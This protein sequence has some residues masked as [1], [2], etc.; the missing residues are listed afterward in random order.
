MIVSGR[1][2]QRGKEV[3]E[4]I[5]AAGGTSAF[6]QADLNTKAAADHLATEAGNAFG[7]IDILVNNAGIF[8][9]G[10]TAQTDETTFDAHIATNVKSPYY[11]TAALAPRMAER[12]SGKVINITTMVAHVGEPGMA[13]YGATKAALALLT[14]SWATEFGPSGV[15]VNAMHPVPHVHPDRGPRGRS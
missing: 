3:V 11:L 4:A 15:N 14:K 12:G 1:N 13:L 6:V 2:A 8:A 5:Q 9:F 10:P 7:P